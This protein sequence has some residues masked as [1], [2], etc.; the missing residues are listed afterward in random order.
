MHCK[1]KPDAPVEPHDFKSICVCVCLCGYSSVYFMIQHFVFGIVCSSINTCSWSSTKESI[2]RERGLISKESYLKHSRE[3]E[4][5]M[6]VVM[7][8]G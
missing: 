3:L 1:G 8:D 2:F 4:L 6:D 7:D 5:L